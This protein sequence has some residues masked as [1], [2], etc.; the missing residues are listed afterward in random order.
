MPAKNSPGGATFHY[1]AI[2]TLRVVS[3]SCCWPDFWN[4]IMFLN[5][6]VRWW[7][8]CEHKGQNHNLNPCQHFMKIW[9]IMFLK[10]CYVRLCLW[11]F[12]SSLQNTEGLMKVVHSVLDEVFILHSFSY[13]NR[14]L[15]RRSPLNMQ[16]MF[17]TVKAL[18]CST[19]LW[20]LEK[21]AE[22]SLMS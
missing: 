21:R 18:L 1:E 10:T 20:K 13:L 3:D 12:T 19:Q 7:L 8:S 17:L 4:H 16:E 15:S 14:R 22:H 9:A 5:E 6:W 2:W 11:F